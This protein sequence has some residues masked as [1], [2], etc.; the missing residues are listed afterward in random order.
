[1]QIRFPV[2]ASISISLTPECSSSAHRS[3][4]QCGSTSHRHRANS[5]LR[6]HVPKSLRA[7]APPALVLEPTNLAPDRLRFHRRERAHS[8]SASAC[9]LPRKSSPSRVQLR[10]SPAPHL[11][12]H[13]LVARGGTTLGTFAGGRCVS[14]GGEN[15]EVI[16]MGEKHE[17]TGIR[18]KGARQGAC[19]FA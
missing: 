17:G 5:R 8:S 2:V 13:G 3:I 18:R 7:S 6:P 11:A 9:A 1:V 12:S 15:R 16:T 19:L 4:K 10:R 14:S